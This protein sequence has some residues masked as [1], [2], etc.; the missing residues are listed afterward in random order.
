MNI[1]HLSK[2]NVFPAKHFVWLIL[3]FLTDPSAMN[4]LNDVDIMGSGMTELI[5]INVNEEVLVLL[6]ETIPTTE[7]IL[8]RFEDITNKTSDYV[9]TNQQ[10]QAIANV[11][12]YYSYLE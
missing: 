3:I 11:L 10:K 9:I 6:K 12:E 5:D 2:V 7:D 8:V 4:K 1:Y